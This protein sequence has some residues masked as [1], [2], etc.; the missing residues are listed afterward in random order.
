MK[1]TLVW[2]LY[3]EMHVPSFRN[4]WCGVFMQAVEVRRAARRER[5]FRDRGNPLDTLY[6]F[7]ELHSRY[8]FAKKGFGRFLA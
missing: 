7:I 4:G 1:Q 2:H 5:V 6:D 3:F 8:R